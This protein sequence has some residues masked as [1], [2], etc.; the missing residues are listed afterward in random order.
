MLEP[1]EIAALHAAGNSGKCK[2]PC[3]NDVNGDGIVGFAD[4][5]AVLSSWGPCDDSCCPADRNGDG[6]VG[7]TDVIAVLSA[8]GPCP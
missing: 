3:F 2:P 5:V 1:D 6:Q 8:W 7:F 4:L